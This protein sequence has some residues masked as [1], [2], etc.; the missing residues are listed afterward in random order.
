ANY[1]RYNKEYRIRLV[2]LLKR[3]KDPKRKV[4]DLII[5]NDDLYDRLLR[6]SMVLIKQHRSSMNWKYEKLISNN[7]AKDI[8]SHNEYNKMILLNLFKSVNTLISRSRYILSEYSSK[9]AALSPVAV[10]QRGYS[11]TRT[12]PD[13]RVIT[14]SKN[15]NIDQKLEVMVAKGTLICRVERK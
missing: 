9:L 7:P 1:I 5:R 2:N 11:I 3:L 12:I 10:L 8:S 14:D 13:K 4:Q 6:T 15:V